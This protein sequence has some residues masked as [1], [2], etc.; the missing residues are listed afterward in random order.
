MYTWFFYLVS[1]YLLKI[2]F[3]RRHPLVLYK[4]FGENKYFREYKMRRNLEK[5]KNNLFVGLKDIT[6]FTLVIWK[7]NKYWFFF[8]FS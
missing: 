1:D 7:I 5:I 8:K 3:K 4:I 2:L 6:Q